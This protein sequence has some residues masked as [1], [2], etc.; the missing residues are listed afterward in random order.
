[1]APFQAQIPH[2]LTNDLPCL[3]AASGMTIPAIWVLYSKPLCAYVI[4]NT[5]CE[6]V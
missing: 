4:L 6:F 3:L 2:P 1:M 5:H